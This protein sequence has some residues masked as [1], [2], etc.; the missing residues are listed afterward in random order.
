[1]LLIIVITPLILFLT[2]GLFGRFIGHKGASILGP[3]FMVLNAVA[4]FF[5]FY[6]VGILG[7]FTY[8]CLGTWVDCGLF[9]VN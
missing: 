6:F 2:L 4:S 7:N 3:A 9:V 1:M 5:A 8:I